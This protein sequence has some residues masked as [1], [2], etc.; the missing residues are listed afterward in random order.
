M[1][2]VRV[3]DLR[4][5]A[6]GRPFGNSDKAVLTHVVK[7]NRASAASTFSG[8][9]ARTASVGRIGAADR[10]SL[11]AR[12]DA[13]SVLRRRRI[14]SGRVGATAATGGDGAFWEKSAVPRAS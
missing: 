11:G 1:K 6:S 9:S 7:R 2:S 3:A 13:R 10:A 5:T 8:V 12:R 14:S 4:V